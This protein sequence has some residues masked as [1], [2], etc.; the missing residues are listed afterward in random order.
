MVRNLE[1][2]G[3]KS[4]F[5]LKILMLNKEAQCQCYLSTTQI[6]FPLSYCY[7]SSL[8]NNAKDSKM[9]IK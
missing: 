7:S 8:D 4:E 5:E 9:N 2:I 1:T 3:D 6:Q